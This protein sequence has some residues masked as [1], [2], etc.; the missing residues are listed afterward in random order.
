MS[1]Q[2]PEGVKSWPAF[3]CFPY[4][5]STW[6][7]WLCEL[8]GQKGKSRG[9]V[10]G[11]CTDLP[12]TE[13]YCNNSVLASELQVHISFK[14]PFYSISLAL[15]QKIWNVSFCSTLGEFP[16]NKK[17]TWQFQGWLSPKPFGKGVIF[18]RNWSQ[19]IFVVHISANSVRKCKPCTH[20]VFKWIILMTRI[21]KCCQPL[22]IWTSMGCQ[23]VQQLTVV[24]V[25]FSK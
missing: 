21:W 3:P 12:G 20:I 5:S 4:P 9:L 8:N 10:S 2:I 7:K 6:V 24:G 17:Y 1:P 14:S 25:D 23:G 19:L 11:V 16:E 15:W 18:L 13:I 22:G